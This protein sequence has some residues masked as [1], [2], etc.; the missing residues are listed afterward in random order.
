MKAQAAMLEVLLSLV[1]LSAIASLSA[2]I[3][4]ASP[5]TQ[6]SY[7]F[8]IGNALYDFGNMLYHND[9]VKACFVS[10]E[11]QCELEIAEGLRSAFALKYVRLSQEGK[12]AERGSERY[13]SMYQERCY[14]V[15]VNGTYSVLCLYAC[16]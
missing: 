11:T 6:R 3:L 16:D 9:S 4:Y 2:N 8:D 13:C 1:I 15:S 7:D 10:A 14:P 5:A 12:T